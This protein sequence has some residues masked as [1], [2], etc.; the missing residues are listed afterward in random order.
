MIEGYLHIEERDGR[1]SIEG[2][3][4]PI[5]TIARVWKLGRSPETIRQDFPV[6]KLAEVYGAIAFY[7]DHQELI[8]QHDA[9]DRVRYQAERATQRAADPER[10]AELERRFA[11]LK[12]RDQAS[13]S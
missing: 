2:Q 11:A 6:L 1:Y 5:A 4:V 13:A 12:A 7:L 8:D 3:R 10:Y 9:E